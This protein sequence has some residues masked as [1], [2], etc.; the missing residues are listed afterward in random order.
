MYTKFTIRLYAFTRSFSISIM[1]RNRH[2]VHQSI[3]HLLFQKTYLNTYT[4]KSNANMFPIYLVS[5][6]SRNLLTSRFFAQFANQRVQA[7]SRWLHNNFAL[8]LYF[9][10]ATVSLIYILN[11]R[12]YT[13]K[14][15]YGFRILDIHFKNTFRCKFG[16]VT[17]A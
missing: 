16:F 1:T 15:L 13:V 10:C 4:R 5:S 12:W 7:D 8:V 2:G 6:V 9:H 3:M 11:I 17:N 14:H